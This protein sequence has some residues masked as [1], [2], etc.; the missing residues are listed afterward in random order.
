MD[1]WIEIVF[2]MKMFLYK[3]SDDIFS[4]AVISI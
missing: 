1:G 3:G 2:P 4:F